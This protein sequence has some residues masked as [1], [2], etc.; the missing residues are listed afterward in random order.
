MVDKKQESVDHFAV[1][2]F[3]FI[4]LLLTFDHSHKNSTLQTHIISAH[5]AH[6]N[7]R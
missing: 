5:Y 6:C 4:L 7:S 3:D 2:S 1:K